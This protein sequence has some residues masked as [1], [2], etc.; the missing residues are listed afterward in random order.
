MF[1][2]GKQGIFLHS[3]KEDKKRLLS[4]CNEEQNVENERN[5]DT[6][7]GFLNLIVNII[8]PVVILTKFSSAEKLGPLY[9]LL[10]AISFPIVYS[11]FRI[12]CCWILPSLQKITK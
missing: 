5:E 9:G 11:N 10:T 2:N 4:I 1:L 3:A 7:E 6:K 12:G 8:I